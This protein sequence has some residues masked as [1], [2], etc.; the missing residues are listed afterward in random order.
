M[1]YSQSYSQKTQNNNYINIIQQNKIAI[2]QLTEKI[3]TL[4]TVENFYDKAQSLLGQSVDVG[5]PPDLDFNYH[6]ELIKI[7]KQS[8]DNVR[9]MLQTQNMRLARYPYQ[10][11][12]PVGIIKLWKK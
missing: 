2:L 3:R 6:Y 1:S 4:E 9:W 7:R 11:F 10:R 12:K 5:L 8:I